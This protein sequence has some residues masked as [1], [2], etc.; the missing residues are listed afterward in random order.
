MTHYP[1]RGR[2]GKRERSDRCGGLRKYCIKGIGWPKCW[3][4][5]KIFKGWGGG[6]GGRAKEGRTK[7]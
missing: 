5:G 6:A 4:L 3:W 7:F 2:E 1:V